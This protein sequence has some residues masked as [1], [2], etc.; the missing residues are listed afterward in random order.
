MAAL[1][2]HGD[3][4]A[5]SRRLLDVVGDEHDRLVQLFLELQQ[6]LLEPLP[7]HGVDRAERLVHEQDRRITAER[8]GHAHPLALAAREFVGKAAAVLRGLE[9]DELEQLLDAGVDPLLVPAEQARHG[10]HVVAHPAV[11]EQATLLNDVA[12]AA[13]QLDRVELED[14]G[15]VDEDPP[16]R[17]LDEAVDHAQ[18]RGLPA[19][20]RADQ[21][22]DLPVGHD[23]AQLRHGHRIGAVALADRVERDHW[24]PGYRPAAPRRGG[25]PDGRP[26]TS[27]SMLPGTTTPSSGG[28]TSPATGTRFRATWSSTFC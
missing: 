19:A 21:D 8:A 20:R 26:L 9:P 14:V 4:V 11:W 1:G 13:A 5:Q 18:R 7:G 3:P 15:V 25:R 24:A 28:A 10:G 6:L 27:T 12:D 23:Q 17:R 16:T 2:Q 22:A